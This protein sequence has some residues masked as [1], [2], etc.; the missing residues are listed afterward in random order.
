MAL[1]QKSLCNGLIVTPRHLFFVNPSISSLCLS[2]HPSVC[3]S[4]FL[5]DRQFVCL[6]VCLSVCLSDCFS[7]LFGGIENDSLSK[8]V[9]FDNPL[10]TN[11]QLLHVSSGSIS[12]LSTA[13]V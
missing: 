5:S 10:L 11:E 1:L 3:L 2:V 9:A 8:D 12:D 6:P 13:E 4:I 7:I